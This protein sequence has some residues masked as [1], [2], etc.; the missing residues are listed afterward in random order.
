MKVARV[1]ERAT[2]TRGAGAVLFANER[3]PQT[4]GSDSRALL[5]R[6]RKKT[7]ALPTYV[8]AYT[9]MTARSF[10]QALSDF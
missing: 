9:R 3:G 1:Q 8:R 7:F 4:L 2:A 10:T 5:F 6:E